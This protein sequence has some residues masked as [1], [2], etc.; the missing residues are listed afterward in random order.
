MTEAGFSSDLYIRWDMDYC[1]FFVDVSPWYC[2]D[3][4]SKKKAAEFG[5]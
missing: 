4:A 1:M 5:G 2:F 3:G